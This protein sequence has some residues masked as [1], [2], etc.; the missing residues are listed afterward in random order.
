VFVPRVCPANQSES[1][2]IGSSKRVEQSIDESLPLN[3][4]NKST[5]SASE[6]KFYYCNCRSLRNRLVEL[7]DLLY[8]AGVNILWFTETWLNEYTTNGMLDPRGLFHIYRH[9]RPGN[10]HGGG[11]C[12]FVA[13]DITS[14]SVDVNLEE[15]NHVDITSCVVRLG[16][17]HV[18]LLC[19]YLPPNLAIDDFLT[20]LKCLRNLC[21]SPDGQ[22][23][24]IGDFNLPHID[25]I[26]SCVA[27]DAKSQEFYDF[28]LEFGLI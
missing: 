16:K 2:P 15:F 11:V 5:H 9:D 8:N 18:T 13:K 21:D 20:N 12:I 28:S 10:N 6:T 27:S 25:W 17:L 23:L 26:N 1:F 3:I 7:H 4:K 19:L 14:H 22:V 24:L